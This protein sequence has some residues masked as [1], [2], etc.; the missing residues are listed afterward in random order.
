MVGTQAAELEL[1]GTKKT[2]DFCHVSLLKALRVQRF[3]LSSISAI[4]DVSLPCNT[5][6]LHDWSY[7]KRSCAALT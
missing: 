7:P 1:P 5:H 2:H 6:V 4:T 3:R